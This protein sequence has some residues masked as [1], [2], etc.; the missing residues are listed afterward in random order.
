MDKPDCESALLA[1]YRFRL[2]PGDVLA[3]EARPREITGWRKSVLFA[4][5]FL[6]GAAAGVVPESWPLLWRWAAV[7]LAGLVFAGFV[8]AAR[9]I[10][11]LRKAR[12]VAGREGR[13]VVE[14]HGDHLAVRSE[15]G[16]RFVPLEMI[17]QVI[18]TDAHVFVRHEGG[19]TIL[20]LRA[21]PD[22]ADMRAYAEALDARSRDAAP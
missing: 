15:S 11:R 21:F 12:R 9:H 6:V 22:A 20:P 16:S 10:L 14:D 2:T 13:T 3:Y 19:P 5:P 17:A 8:L 4:I 18:R 7:V 1:A